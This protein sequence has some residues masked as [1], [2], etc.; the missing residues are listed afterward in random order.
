MRRRS[1]TAG[2]Q[3]TLKTWSAWRL[4]HLSPDSLLQ[5]AALTKETENPRA[6]ISPGDSHGVRA[7]MFWQAG[8]LM[9]HAET[10]GP[11]R[12]DASATRTD[13]GDEESQARA[14][15]APRHPRGS[16][17]RRQGQGAGT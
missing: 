1:A 12:A 16:R 14:A 2:L 4:G 9:K 5:S 7:A 11:S 3:E 15:V 10:Y 13:P 17:I 6:V 8:C